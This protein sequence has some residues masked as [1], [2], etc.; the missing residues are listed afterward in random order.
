MYTPDRQINPPD[1]YEKDRVTEQQLLDQIAV[2]E[3]KQD[4]KYN[5]MASFYS[6][7]HKSKERIEWIKR[8]NA[9]PYEVAGGYFARQQDL[10]KAEKAFNWIDKTIT[11]IENEI[12]SIQLEVEELERD[13]KRL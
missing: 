12:S 7:Y 5:F 11:R 2:L 4:E 13:L 10:L 3:K 1:F 6:V 9:I 8:S